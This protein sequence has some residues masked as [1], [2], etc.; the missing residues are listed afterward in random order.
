MARRAFYS[1][2]YKPD[3]WRASQVR[4]MGVVE[5]NRPASD[6]DWETIKKGGDTAI[7]KWIDGQL[8]GKSV[9]IVLIGEKTAGRKWIKY[10]IKKAWEDGKGVLG[11]YVHNLKDKDGNQSTKGSNP[12]SVYNI[13]DKN[14]SN[15]VMAYDPPYSTSKKVYDYIKKNLADWIEEAIEIRGEYD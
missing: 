7:K 9:A 15:I 4:N 2:H 13:G 3:N 6:N 1:F 12:F 5:G 8:S 11:I 14:M 10:E